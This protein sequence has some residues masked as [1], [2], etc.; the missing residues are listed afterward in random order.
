[1]RMVL[2]VGFVGRI[3]KKNREERREVAVLWCGFVVIDGGGC[4][5]VMVVGCRPG[6]R[7]KKECRGRRSLREKK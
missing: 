7:T 3:G 4:L 6:G 2:G 1:M 5:W